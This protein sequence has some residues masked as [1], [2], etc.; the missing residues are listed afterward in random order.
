MPLTIWMTKVW[1]F[2]EPVG[3]LQFSTEGWRDK[4]RSDLKPGDRVV[5]VGTLGV[6][7]K[8]DDRSRL[9]GM[10]EP[11]T[12]PVM[13]LD[14]LTADRPEDLNEQGQYKWPHGLLNRAAWRFEAPRARL[15]DISDRR[16]SMDSAQ[17]IVPLTEAEA[18]EVMKLPRTPV[19]LLE[20]FKATV[21]IEGESAAQRRGAPPPSTTRAGIM[22]M[23]R[24]PAF[25]YALVIEES[26]KGFRP[27]VAGFKIGWAFEW[28]SRM[29]SFNQAAMPE[30]GGLRYRGCMKQLWS[31]A[32]DAYRMEQ[33]VLRRFGHVRHDNNQEVVTGISEDELASEWAQCMARISRGLG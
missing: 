14:Y 20:S 7:T 23:R 25:T 24:A 13:A 18:V 30:L 16:F 8:E 15:A 29:R 6:E 26:R 33:A 5:L 17:G 32:M 10:M 4:A 12:E 21:R 28:T 19:A 9:L 3:P 27:R 1:G 22:H 2:G 31:T 11:T